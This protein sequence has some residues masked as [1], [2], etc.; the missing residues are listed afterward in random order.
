MNSKGA[1]IPIR[2]CALESLVDGL[3]TIKTDT[4]S[5]PRFALLIVL[6]SLRYKWSYGVTLWEIMSLGKM[7]YPGVAVQDIVSFL[8]SGDRLDRP[9]NCPEEM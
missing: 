5:L 4:V 6:V 7:P 8:E 3:F 2:W 1:R 9:S